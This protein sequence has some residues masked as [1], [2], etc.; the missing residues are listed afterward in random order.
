MMTNESKLKHD[1]MMRLLR[2]LLFFGLLFEGIGMLRLNVL[3]ATFAV[4]L[5]I[6]A[7]AH[8]LLNRGVNSA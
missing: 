1:Q 4:F 8:F 6:V 2:K 5:A 3:L 7:C